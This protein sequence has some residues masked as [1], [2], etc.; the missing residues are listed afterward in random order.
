MNTCGFENH[1]TSRFTSYEA[2]EVSKEYHFSEWFDALQQHS[3]IPTFESVILQ[4][5]DL[6]NGKVDEVIQQWGGQCFA[7]LDPCS[8]KPTAPFT[9]AREVQ[10]HIEQSEQTNQLLGKP[11]I[12]LILRKWYPNL[13]GEFRC[14]VHDSQLRAISSEE[15]LSAGTIEAVQEALAKITHCCEY[16]NYCADFTLIGGQLHL[17]EINTPVWLFATSGL[18]DLSVVADRE[19]LVGEYIPDIISYPVVRC[20]EDVDD[21]PLT[22]ALCM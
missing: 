13:G 22:Q 16:A 9:S 2:N 1:L 17:I 14:F 10:E 18:F 20:Q 11:S 12:P 8:S 6:F 19:I 5:G 21:S 4:W 7:R 3:N 15:H